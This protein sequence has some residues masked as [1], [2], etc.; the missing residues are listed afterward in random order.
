MNRLIITGELIEQ[1]PL[2][3]TPAGVPVLEFKLAHDGQSDEAGVTRRIQF[4]ISVVA[5]A[6]L[7]SMYQSLRL[8]SLLEVE[9]FIAAARKGSPRFRLHAANIR[10]V[11]PDQN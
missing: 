9:G 3:T 10:I 7:A 2:R 5:L 6:E 11:D 8:G 1:S 4:D